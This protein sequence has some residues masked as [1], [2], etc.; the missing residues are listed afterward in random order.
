MDGTVSTTLD[1]EFS[2]SPK[3]RKLYYVYLTII[4]PITVLPWYIPLV[5]KGPLAAVLGTLVPIVIVPFF[6]LHW[7]PRFYDSISYTLT[8][9]EIVWR[10]GVWFRNTGI[11]PYNRIT[12][13]DIAQGPISRSLGIA[14]LKVQTAGYSA[15]RKAEI[16]LEGIENSE[17]LRE[18]IMNFV[19][20]EKP[21]AV[22]TFAGEESINAKILGELTR[23]REL[24]ERII[25]KVGEKQH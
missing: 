1:K 5:I 6:L 8:D 13:V 19:R 10:R 25:G 3:F 4:F 23:I 24:V 12:N 16:R 7:I 14:A 9:A 15:E 21:Q 22:E 20:G 18:S 2:P 11:V 17:E